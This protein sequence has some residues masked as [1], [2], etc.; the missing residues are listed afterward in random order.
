M[1]LTM[2]V[3]SLVTTY[4]DY[5]IDPAASFL[6]IKTLSKED[7]TTTTLK[8]AILQAF[9]LSFQQDDS[10]F[11]HSP[12]R[13]QR[14]LPAVIAPMSQNA[15][16]STLTEQTIAATTSLAVAVA[17]VPDH[18][19]KLTDSLVTLC[20]SESPKIRVTAVRTMRRLTDT[21]GLGADW[22]GQC[23]PRMKQV[24]AE[25][26]EDDVEA[27]ERETTGW[28]KAMEACSG[29]RIEDTLA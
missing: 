2:R 19:D 9:S 27:V 23:L 24:V 15:P 10:S 21:E 28:I 12:S 25:L 18:L 22:L 29:E 20:K 17:A 11:Y 8:L 5:A 3:Q 7:K 6:N 13:F 16:S 14:L 4:F 26:Q 1:I